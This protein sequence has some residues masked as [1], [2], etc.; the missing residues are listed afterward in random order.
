MSKVSYLK[1]IINDKFKTD[2][3]NVALLLR[4]LSKTE[5]KE[6]SRWYVVTR[7]PFGFIKFEK[8]KGV[9]DEDN[10]Q[11]KLCQEV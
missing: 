4:F 11:L 6:L 5:E 3:A 2:P 1:K 10:R 7:E 9:F 8:R